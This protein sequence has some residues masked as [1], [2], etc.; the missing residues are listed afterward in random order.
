MTDQ[1]LT[2]LIKGIEEDTIALLKI[3]GELGKCPFCGG[4]AR[5]KCDPSGKEWGRDYWVECRSCHARSGTASVLNQSGMIFE[6][7]ERAT[8]YLKWL[9]GRRSNG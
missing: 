8:L 1:E 6:S 4:I 2:D 3:P 9:W 5:I 7:E